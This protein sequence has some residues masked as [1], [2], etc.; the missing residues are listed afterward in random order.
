MTG[1]QTCA[2]PILKLKIQLTIP[3]IIHNAEDM[4]E[5]S[6]RHIYSVW[7]ILIAF[8][9]LFLCAGN[10]LLHRVSRDSR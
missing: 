4:F 6:A 5:A 8:I 7:G 2:L 3:D 1:V 9:L 10:I